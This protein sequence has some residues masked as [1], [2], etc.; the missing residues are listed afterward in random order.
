M[1]HIRSNTTPGNFV[2]TSLDINIAKDFAGKNGYVYE[3]KTTNYIDVNKQLGNKSL[4]PEQKEF[5]IPGG[6][7]AEEIKGVYIKKKG[8]FTGEYINNPNFKNTK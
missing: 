8:V 2:S 5:S 1:A 6:I 4:Y 7:K 3:I